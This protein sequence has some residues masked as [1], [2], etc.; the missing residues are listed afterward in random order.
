ML[1]AKRHGKDFV[2]KNEQTLI[3][4]GAYLLDAYMANVWPAM[5]VTWGT[6]KGHNGHKNESEGFGC[7]RCHDD[8]H[9]TEFGK[10][11]S[12]SCDLCHDEP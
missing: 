7:F 1:Q 8:Q 12:Q 4:S 5:K 3:S 9:Q 10:T 6:Y 11:I 2:A